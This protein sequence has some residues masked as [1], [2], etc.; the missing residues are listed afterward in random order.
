MSEKR[1]TV[2]VLHVVGSLAPDSGGPAR[3]VP[4]LCA[5]LS[6]GGADVTL[7]SRR[8]PGTVPCVLDAGGVALE[9]RD[10]LSG[11][12]TRE[13][14]RNAM[15]DRHDAV[16]HSHGVW[17]PCN[18]AASTAAR[19][20]GVAHVISPRGMLEPWSLRYHRLRKRLAWRLYQRRDIAAAA[21]LHATSESEADNLCAL[22]LTNPVAVIPNA[23]TLPAGLPPRPGQASRTALFLSRIHPKKGL[24]DL[25]SAWAAVRPPGWRMVVAGPDESGHL[26][27]VKAAAQA[28]GVAGDFSF[29]GPLDDDAK[30]AAYREAEL[31]ILPSFSENFG[32]VVAEAMSAGLPVI[33]TRATP[34]RLL[35]DAQCGW[36]IDT[37]ADALAQAVR[38]AT[39]LPGEARA[40]MGSLAAAA[41]RERFRWDRVA[42]AMRQV[43]AWL[44]GQGEPPSCVRTNTTA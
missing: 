5:A 12:V 13:A 29:P 19:A 32:V 9:L 37:G 22:G 1:A 43:Y 25:V 35:R 39:S 15:R 34:W 21:V 11:G 38:E 28:A 23:V 41:A 18:H 44:A 7:L 40:R 42:E 30:W 31:F 14:I 17:L 33:T 2:S 10:R 16:L 3:T 6:A 4:A 27:K 24:L 20:L 36:W 8:P 26:A